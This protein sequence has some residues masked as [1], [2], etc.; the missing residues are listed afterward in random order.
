MYSSLRLL[1]C[2][3]KALV[4]RATFPPKMR[5]N[6]PRSRAVRHQTKSVMTTTAAFAF[7]RPL[8]QEACVIFGPRQSACSAP[9]MIVCAVCLSE[10]F[11]T[12][13]QRPCPSGPALVQGVVYVC[14]PNVCGVF[15]SSRGV[16]SKFVSARKF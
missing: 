4:R 15:R 6:S 14:A 16:V 12:N 5:G 1:V 10:S 9:L 3:H 8:P 11:N 13:P 2:R 7:A